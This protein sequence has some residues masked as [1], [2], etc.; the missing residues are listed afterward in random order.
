MQ[1]KS[2]TAMNDRCLEMQKS[3]RKKAG[4]GGRGREGGSYN[5][6]YLVAVKMEKQRTS[7]G[8]AKNKQRRKR[9][10]PSAHCP[11]YKA[12]ALGT[13]RDMALVRRSIVHVTY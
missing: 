2:I 7:E 1:L 3:K 4:E 13:F 6:P 11:F 9:S 8:Q 12:G 10:T 5:N